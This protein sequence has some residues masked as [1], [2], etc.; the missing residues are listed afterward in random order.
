VRVVLLNA[1]KSTRLGGHN[2]LFVNAGGVPVHRWH[3]RALADHEVALVTR[4][5]DIPRSLAELPWLTRVVGHDLLDG[6]LGALSAYLNA[7]NDDEQI[8]VLYSDTLFPEQPLPTGDWVGV[9]PLI[10]RTWDH[11]VGAGEGRRWVKQTPDLD[12]GV[13]IYGFADLALLRDCIARLGTKEDA[14]LPELLNL[15]GARVG[16]G[17]HRIVGWHDA[18]DPDALSRVPSFDS[19]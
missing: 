8:A 14:H 9:A 4:T 1:G 13:G 11:L 10:T 5:E 18:G 12:V 2:K 17:T 15:Y 3:Q 16:V 6:P 7:F 19:R